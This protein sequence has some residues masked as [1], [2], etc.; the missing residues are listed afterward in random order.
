MN[1]IKE[2]VESYK[3]EFDSPLMAIAY[4]EYHNYVNKPYKKISKILKNMKNDMDIYRNFVFLI[5]N[6][7]FTILED[8]QQDILRLNKVDINIKKY[9][10]NCNTWEDFEKYVIEENASKYL[11][12]QDKNNI[13]IECE[14]I[15]KKYGFLNVIIDDFNNPMIFLNDFDENLES[16]CD[17][18]NIEY[19][20]LGLNKL[21]IRY[22]SRNKFSYYE[23]SDKLILL[24]SIDAF[25]HEWMHF[26]DKDLI[27]NNDDLYNNYGNLIYENKNLRF[28]KF[29]NLS[30]V[31][32]NDLIK[33][34]NSL[35]KDIEEFKQFGNIFIDEDSKI[36]DDFSI[37]KFMEALFLISFGEIND[38]EKLKILHSIYEEIDSY[39]T[40][41][42]TLDDMRLSRYY[43]RLKGLHIQHADVL[44]VRTRSE[45]IEKAFIE[46]SRDLS[47]ELK[48][49]KDFKGTSL[50]RISQMGDKFF[51]YNYLQSHFEI[52]ARSFEFY[53]ND[54]IPENK[55]S[56][57]KMMNSEAFECFYPNNEMKSKTIDFWDNLLP[58]LT[59]KYFAKKNGPKSKVVI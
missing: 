26:I 2:I 10:K 7:Q 23:D 43:G 48:D 35:Y 53:L 22:K 56:K 47:K 52:L 20:S 27:H 21:S 9:F 5:H 14:R 11:N 50:L 17:F 32:K 12:S 57:L 41:N 42:D 33:N 36:N 49:N 28:N 8:Y 39:I 40:K 51:G 6:L 58:K 25:A 18:L 34:F 59:N 3:K 19:S 31:I 46:V 4:I 38:K 24:N 44:A 1:N 13:R 29:L 45:E 37:K 15:A 54:K 30:D 16:F 55:L